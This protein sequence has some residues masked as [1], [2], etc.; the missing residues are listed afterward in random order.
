MNKIKYALVDQHL[1]LRDEKESK[2]RK[3]KHLN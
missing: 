2:K 3:A 1:K